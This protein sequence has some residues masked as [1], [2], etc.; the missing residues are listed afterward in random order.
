MID[1]NK[2]DLSILE[3]KTKLNK[4]LIMKYFKQFLKKYPKGRIKK[5]EFINDI[6][7]N[8]VIEEKCADHESVEQKKEKIK[9]CE[10]VF[11][12]CDQDESGKVDF[13]E[14]SILAF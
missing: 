9:L 14:V 10:R 7:V 3:D 2:D 6:V 11:D 13:V 1:L 8:L 12:I 5:D 4:D